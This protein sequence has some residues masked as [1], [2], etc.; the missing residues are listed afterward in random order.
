[1]NN[2][3]RGQSQPLGAKFTPRGKLHSWWPTNFGKNWRQIDFSN[4]FFSSENH[5]PREIP[6]HTP[7]KEI[8]RK[9]D[10]IR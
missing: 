1:M 9:I 2:I 10:S 8:V 6:F 3:P 5:S 4:N 7:E